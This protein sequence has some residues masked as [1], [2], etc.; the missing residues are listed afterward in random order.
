MKWTINN[1]RFVKLGYEVN[2]FE[3]KEIDLI[4]VEELH[5]LQKKHPDQILVNIFGKT[6]KASEAND[7]DRGGYASYALLENIK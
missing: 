4:T 2:E 1:S 3:G 6:C 7:D 5:F